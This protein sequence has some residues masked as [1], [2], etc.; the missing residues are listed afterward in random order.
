MSDAAAIAEPA[1]ARPVARPG[2]LRGCYTFITGMCSFYFVIACCSLYWLVGAGA[3]LFSKILPRS[4]VERAPF[5]FLLASTV[6]MSAAT[7]TIPNFFPN[8]A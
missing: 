3:W 6:L 5:A 4:I 7:Q 2:F 8:S 1:S